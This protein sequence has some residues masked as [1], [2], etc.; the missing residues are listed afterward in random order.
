[1]PRLVGE[2]RNPITPISLLVLIVAGAIIGLEYVG[3]TDF[4]PGFGRNSPYLGN[5]NPSSMN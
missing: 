3:A 4:V 5:S 1:M 2:Q